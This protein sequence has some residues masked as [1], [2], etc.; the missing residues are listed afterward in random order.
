MTRDVGHQTHFDPDDPGR[1]AQALGHDRGSRPAG[2]S[3]RSGQFGTDNTGYQAMLA[4]AAAWP[5]RVWAVEGCNGVGKHLSQ[6][7]VADGEIVVDV[8]AKLSARTRVFSTGHGRK[9]DDTDARSVA[10]VALVALRT[11]GLNQVV[12][13]DH[14]VALRLLVDRRDELGRTRTDTVNRLHKLLAELIPGGATKILSATQAKSLL[15][16]VRPRDIVGKTRRALAADLI[17]ELAGLD[18][19]MKTADKHLDELLDVT[20]TTL[21]DL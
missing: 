8:P 5:R 20:G 13:D 17:T 7:L 9:T 16:S 19:T 10:L 11:D 6:R 1:P 12:E 18:R 3:A 4:A 15:A 2:T 21:R 14:T